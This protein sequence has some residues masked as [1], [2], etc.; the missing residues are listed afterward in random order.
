[1]DPE[2]EKQQIESV[3]EVKRNRD[4]Q[5]V[6]NSLDK[7]KQAAEGDANLVPPAIEAVKNFATLGEVVETLAGVFGIF[8]RPLYY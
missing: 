7:L 8:E 4:K 2:L 6:Q 1:L 5:T 3:R